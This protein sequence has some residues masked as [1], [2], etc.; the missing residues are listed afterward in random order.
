MKG[1][2]TILLDRFLTLKSD[3]VPGVTMIPLL[4]NV[5]STVVGSR[6]GNLKKYGYFQ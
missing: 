1:N 5:N 2:A 3:F 6:K 4:N